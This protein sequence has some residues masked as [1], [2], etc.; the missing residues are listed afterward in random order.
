[1]ASDKVKHVFGP[2]PSRRLGRSLGVDLVP[3]KTCTFDCI[4]CQLGCT[5]DKTIDRREWVPLGDLLE[6]VKAAL[7]REPD[8]VTLSG[9]GEPTLYARL[10]ELIAGIRSMTSVPVAV[11][12]NGSLFWKPEVRKELLQADLVVPSLDAGTERSYLQVNRPHSEVTFERL[13]EGL[14]AFGREYAGQLWL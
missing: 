6:D 8:Y 13:I 4:Y 2:V 11:L 12:T 3:Y 7:V 9:S 1:V 10:G 5:T 14:E